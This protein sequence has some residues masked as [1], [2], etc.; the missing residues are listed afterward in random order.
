[1][2]RGRCP[3]DRASDGEDGE[4]VGQHHEE[5]V[6]D[7]KVED[8]GT[9]LERISGSEQE[10]RHG[11]QDRVPSPEDDRAKDDEPTPRVIPGVK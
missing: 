8:L 4:Q 6:R 5:L 3:A 11:C 1:M 9:K 10:T 2:P 7:P